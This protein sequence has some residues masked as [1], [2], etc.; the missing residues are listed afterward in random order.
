MP[1]PAIKVTR[2]APIKDLP[3][4]GPSTV[5]AP[6]TGY[7]IVKNKSNCEYLCLIFL[8]NST[9][10]K[11]KKGKIRG[12]IGVSPPDKLLLLLASPLYKKYSGEN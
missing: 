7:K 11:I 1:I 5:I 3:L 4:N 8:N 10:P 6:P 12:N 9:N 2:R